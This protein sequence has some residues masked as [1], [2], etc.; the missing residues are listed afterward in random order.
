MERTP[1][2]HV[3]RRALLAAGAAFVVAGCRFEERPPN[4]S[5]RDDAALQSVATAFYRSMGG[6]DS[7]GLRAAVFPAATMIVDGGRNAPTLVPVRTLLELPERRTA[8]GGVRIV[9]TE[10]HADGA[11]ATARVTIAAQGPGDEGEFE[12]SDFLTLARRDGGWRVAHAVLGPWR[13]RS[14]P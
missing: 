10:L 5:R 14:A 3:A 13:P 11:V 9:H 4:G 7:S 12:A 8:K 1:A 2:R 6:R